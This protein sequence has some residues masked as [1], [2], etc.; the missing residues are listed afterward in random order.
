MLMKNIPSQIA[1]LLITAGLAFISFYEW[2]ALNTID[3]PAPRKIDAAYCTSCHTDSATMRAMKLKEGN[4][5]FIFPGKTAVI[6][7]GECPRLTG[8]KRY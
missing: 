6:P 4:T 1:I 2:H 5:H 8:K 7:T 3:H